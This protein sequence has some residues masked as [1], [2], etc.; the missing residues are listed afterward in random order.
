M[1]R[2]EDRLSMYPSKHLKLAGRET[3]LLGLSEDD[4]YFSTI[5]DGF[6][7]P[8]HALVVDHLSPDAVALDVGANIGVTSLILSRFLTNGRV[9]AFEPS[10]TVFRILEANLRNNEAVNV[11]PIRLAVG[12]E[13]GALE[14]VDMSAYGH[15]VQSESMEDT[16]HVVA[17]DVVTLDQ[18]VKDNS[19][20]RIDL[21]KI[22]TEGFEHNVFLGMTGIEEM[23][24]PLVYF[25]FNSWCLIAFNN[26]NPR[27][28][29]NY[30]L[31]RFSAVFYFDETG[32]PLRLTK[33]NTME[34]LHR[35]LV[36]HGCVDNLL[37]TNDPVRFGLE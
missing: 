6:E 22:D 29:L 14:F 10:P 33:H 25:E 28:F 35:N 19:I 8:F 32:S 20:D 15:I 12:S 1:L 21:L 24:R 23:F 36:E 7:Q 13:K 37:A 4:P 9:F 17:V 3:T 18:F 30:I 2:S 26:E 34:F 16:A 11:T 31:S 5:F 27:E